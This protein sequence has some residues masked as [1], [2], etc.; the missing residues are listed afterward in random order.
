MTFPSEFPTVLQ[1]TGNNTDARLN[2]TQSATYHI[3]FF[4]DIHNKG[5]NWFYTD[6][7]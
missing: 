5:T 3:D 7:R 6:C 4:A 2:N 1:L